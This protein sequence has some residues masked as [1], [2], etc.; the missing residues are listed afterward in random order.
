MSVGATLAD[1]AGYYGIQFSE[2]TTGMLQAVNHLYTHI[3]SRLDGDKP[4]SFPDNPTA[5]VRRGLELPW[6]SYG[7]YLDGTQPA[8]GVQHDGQLTDEQARAYD[9][10]RAAFDQAGTPV[11]QRRTFTAGLYAWI[12]RA[13][14]AKTAT[15]ATGGRPDQGYVPGR[16]QETNLLAMAFLDVLPPEVRGHENYQ[17][18]ARTA[19]RLITGYKLFDSFI[20]MGKDIRNHNTAL[21]NKRVG[22]LAL[23]GAAVRAGLR[24]LPTFL[25]YPGLPIKIGKKMLAGGR[26]VNDTRNIDRTQV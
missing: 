5:E 16:I 4:N 10:L 14:Y 6:L 17:K 11:A 18:F 26:N 23:V 3:D 19:M 13:E 21:T 9:R 12:L 8:V 22:Q 20:D 1:V 2:Q 7:N 25:R 15:Q 24:M